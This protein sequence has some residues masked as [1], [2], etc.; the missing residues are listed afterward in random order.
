M[1]TYNPAQAACGY[2]DLPAGQWPFGAFAAIDP[3]AS[4]FAAGVQQGCGACLEVQCADP[5]QC[6]SAS[7][8][9]LVVQV[10][11]HCSGCGASAIYL[12]PD[13]FGRIVS[14]G[15]GQVSARFRRVSELSWVPR[16]CVQP[17]KA[18]QLRERRFRFPPREALVHVTLPSSPRR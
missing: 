14:S 18:P 6:G 1:Q 15:L 17:F 12:A 7:A 13:A 2:G 5:S 9:S 11:D 4:P 16:D 10:I 8:S 3:A